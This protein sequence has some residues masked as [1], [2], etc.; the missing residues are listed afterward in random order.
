MAVDE[1]N[2]NIIEQAGDYNLEICNILS[3]RRNDEEGVNYEMDLVSG[4]VIQFL[5]LKEDI[6]S[7]SILGSVTVYDAQDIRTILPITGLE[8]LELKFNTPGLP[9]YNNVRGE[10]FPFQIYKIEKVEVDQT[11]PRAQ[12]Y[13]ILFCSPEAYRN[14]ITRVSQAYAG[15]VE[16]GVNSILRDPLYLNS[17]KRFFI[18]PTNT[19][20]KIVVPNFKPFRAIQLLGKDAISQKYN[21]AGYF[22]YETTDGYHFR[23]LESMIASGGNMPRPIKFNYYYQIANSNT[24]KNVKDVEMDMKGVI[25]Y[26]F[27]RPVNML[28][29]VNKGLY[30]SK[31]FTHDTFYKTYEE[32]NYD[33]FEDFKNHFHLE[34]DSGGEKARFKGVL[35]IHPYEDTRKDFGQHSDARVMVESN[36]SKIHNDYEIIDP[37]VTVQQKNSQRLAMNNIN[38]SL[39]VFGN[40]AINAGDVITFDI[41][42]MRP[43]IEEG[44]T[45]E[46]NPFYSGRYLVMAVKHIINPTLLR[47][48]MVLK[49]MKDSVNTEFV[50][51]TT[52][53]TPT[54]KDFTRKV[55]NIYEIDQN[56]YNESIGDGF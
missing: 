7:N 42:L 21:N 8:K 37:K 19:N 46:S 50:A 41:P 20:T 15:P 48:E 53:F 3:Y 49:C 27:E 38:L 26:E 9:G 29:N 30:A 11:N 44:D 17:K 4:G 47:H 18:E 1:K 45:Q 55:E 32:K 52:E 33:Y 2:P 24:D 54:L 13:R 23:S 43:L 25:K 5:E 31:L 34:F 16:N 56:Y 51:E 36:T 28:E 10:G 40:T 14:S 12:R 22:F 39:Q 35:P 6:L